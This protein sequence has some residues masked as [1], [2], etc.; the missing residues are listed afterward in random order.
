MSYG[1]KFPLFYSNRNLYGLYES[2]INDN[3]G[4][5]VYFDF[6]QI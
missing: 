6:T 5:R 1:M 2:D 3:I 4:F